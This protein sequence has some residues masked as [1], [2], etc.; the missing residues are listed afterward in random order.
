MVQNFRALANSDP[1]K[2]TI[3]FDTMY[4]YAYM[5]LKNSDES[6]WKSEGYKGSL[7]VNVAPFPSLLFSAQILP[8]CASIM[9][10][11]MNSPRP[12][13]VWD[14]VVNFVKSL[15]MISGSIPE[16]VSLTD[17]MSCPSICLKSG[18]YCSA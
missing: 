4:N 2:S 7:K 5:R 9:L 12:V 16:P 11:E 6:K 10:L 8:P 1:H 13:P 15:D 3:S 18:I 17:T 14:L